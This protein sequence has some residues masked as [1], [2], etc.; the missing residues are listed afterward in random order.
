MNRREL[1]GEGKRRFFFSVDPGEE[2]GGLN[3]WYAMELQ[4]LSKA[5]DPK[6]YVL[7]MLLQ[8]RGEQ[9]VGPDEVDM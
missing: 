9:V 4:R 5:G 2:S 3:R 7:K 6:V 8:T 1:D